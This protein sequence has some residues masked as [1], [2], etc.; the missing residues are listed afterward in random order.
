MKDFAI[1][2]EIQREF[3]RDIVI[4]TSPTANPD[5]FN[6]LDSI[7]KLYNQ[8]HKTSVE[9]LVEIYKKEF[10]DGKT[11]EIKIRMNDPGKKKI[12]DL[13]KNMKQG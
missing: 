12:S 3:Y 9:K 1:E 2:L 11:K 7:Q 8:E 10:T 4:L 6:V 5:K 13:V